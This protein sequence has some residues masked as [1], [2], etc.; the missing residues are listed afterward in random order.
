MISSVNSSSKKLYKTFEKIFQYQFSLQAM[1]VIILLAIFQLLI[2]DH[3]Y[4]FSLSLGHPMYQTSLE[5]DQRARENVKSNLKDF[6]GQLKTILGSL[7]DRWEK[8]VT[9]ANTSYIIKT[10]IFIWIG[11]RVRFCVKWQYQK[12][13]RRWKKGTRKLNSY[14]KNWLIGLSH[15]WILNI[16]WIMRKYL[17]G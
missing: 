4:S 16:S 7:C 12:C 8:L 5:Y 17:R 14:N 1:R 13:W 11:L 3:A 2:S 15:L 9:S 6:Q 10:C